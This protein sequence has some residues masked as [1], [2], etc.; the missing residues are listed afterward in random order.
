MKNCIRIGII[1][2]VMKIGNSGGKSLVLWSQ[3]A[4]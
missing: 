1:V 2:H 4:F 3:I